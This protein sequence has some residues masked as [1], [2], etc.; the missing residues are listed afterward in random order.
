MKTVKSILAATFVA[1]SIVAVA[2]NPGKKPP[3]TLKVDTNAS[4]FNWLA[5]KLTG[6]H[7]GTVKIQSG[8]LITDG[9]KLTGGDFTIDLSTIKDLDIQ[10]DFAGKLETHLKSA[11]FFDVAKFPTSTLKITKAV[12]K[13]GENYDLTGDLTIR[14]ISQSIT[15]PATVKIAGKTASASAKFD[16]DRTKFGLTYRSKSFFENIG[17][18]MIYDNFTV[19]VK[20]VAGA[21]M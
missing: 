13:G 12:A 16:V 7:N 4:T 15:F 10:G 11:D 9:S 17:D 18:K 8:N 1:L 2:N 21:P 14:G 3:Q 5:K 19:E 20:I 6:E